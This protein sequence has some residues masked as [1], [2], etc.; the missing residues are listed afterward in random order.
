MAKYVVEK[1]FFDRFDND[2]H[3][4]PGEPHVPPNEER[5]EQ[6][7]KQGFISVVD[8]KTDDKPKEGKS[9]GARKVPGKKKEDEVKAGDGDGEATAGE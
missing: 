3:C 5:A 2:R 8:K 7:L 1:D 4:R 6:L 9:T